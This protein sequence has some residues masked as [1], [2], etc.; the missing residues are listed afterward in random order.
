MMIKS[1]IR[2]TAGGTIVLC[3]KLAFVEPFLLAVEVI[4]FDGRLIAS[5]WLMTL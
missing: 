1:T 2:E 4:E 5:E 3:D